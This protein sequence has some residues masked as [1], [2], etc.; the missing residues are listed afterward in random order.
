[1]TVLLEILSYTGPHDIHEMAKQQQIS[2]ILIQHHLHFLGTSQGC[3]MP[4]WRAGSLVPVDGKRSVGGQ[5]RRWNDMVSNDL[6]LC[7]ML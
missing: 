4:P 7:N 2:S 6:R 5:K 1:M 3:L